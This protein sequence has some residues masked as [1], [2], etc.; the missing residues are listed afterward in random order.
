VLAAASLNAV[1]GNTALILGM[2]GSLFGA[3]VIGMAV[4]TGNRAVLRTAPRYAWL[5][6]GAGIAAFAVM[7]RALINRDWALSYVQQVGST[8]TPPLYNVTALWSA[9]EGSILLWILVLAGYIAAVMRKYR[10]R[11]EDPLV[12]WAMVV[13]FAVSA[14]FFFLAF[15][16]TEVFKTAGSPDFSRCCLGP[17]PLLQ[18]HVLVLFHPPILYLGFVG[19]TVPFA[20]AIAALITGRV[21]EGWL[22]DTRRWALFA[23]GFLTLGIILGGWWSYEV[24]GWGGAWGWDPVEN[25]SLLP[26]LTGTAYIHPVMVQERRGMLRVWNISLLVATFALTILGTFLT[27]R[28]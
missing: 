7:A 14:F 11:L 4:R 5:I 6:L 1:L 26:W 24:L 15:G 8:S 28:A 10:R 25:A 23:W 16:P 12:G 27:R 22:V 3:L 18:N 20:F 21:G 2:V 19:F 17:V 9:L 13:M